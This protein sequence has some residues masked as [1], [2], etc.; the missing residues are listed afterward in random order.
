MKPLN[1]KTLVFRD[2]C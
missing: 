1:W 2:L